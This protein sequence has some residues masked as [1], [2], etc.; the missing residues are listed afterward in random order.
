MYSGSFLSS[1]S[2]TFNFFF[3]DFELNLIII[4]HIIIFIVFTYFL[5]FNYYTNKINIKFI[6]TT[7]VNT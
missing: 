6:D 4:L 7:L 1:I 3:L 2:Y 5:F